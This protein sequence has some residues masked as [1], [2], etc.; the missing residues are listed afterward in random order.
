[1]HLTLISRSVALRYR[2]V[3]SPDIWAS[4]GVKYVLPSLRLLISSDSIY[5]CYFS[6]LIAVLLILM[7]ETLS[8]PTIPPI[9]LENRKKKNKRKRRY[10]ITGY[11]V[12]ILNCDSPC[13]DDAVTR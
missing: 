4:R 2:L 3:F 8:F 11:T 10:S 5:F 9:T 1:M 13:L 6:I 7:P 12:Y